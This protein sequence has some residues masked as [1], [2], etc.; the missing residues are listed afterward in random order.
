MPSLNRA[1]PFKK[2]DS[3]AFRISEG[4]ALD[5]PYDDVVIALVVNPSPPTLEGDETAVNSKTA[6]LT[7]ASGRSGELV[8]ILRREHL[9]Y[10]GLLIAQDVDGKVSAVQ[11]GAQISARL[12][13]AEQHQRGVQRKRGEGADRDARWLSVLVGCRYHAD[14][15][16]EPAERLAKCSAIDRHR[17]VTRA[18]IAVIG[19][20]IKTCIT[21]AC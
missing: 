19:A 13:N 3:I 21:T 20:C 6:I 8:I 16:G 4:R 1:V 9:G 2:V 15:G 12:A 18:T 10:D 7:R 11:P 17:Q 14:A 5:Q